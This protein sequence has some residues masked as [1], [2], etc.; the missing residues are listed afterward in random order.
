MYNLGVGLGERGLF[1]KHNIKLSRLAISPLISY[2]ETANV[3]T[4]NKKLAVL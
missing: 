4:T 2:Q 3:F 1:G